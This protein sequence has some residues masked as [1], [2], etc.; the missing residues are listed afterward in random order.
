MNIG[1][2]GLIGNFVV[3]VS[4]FQR[5]CAK[6]MPE[7]VRCDFVRVTIAQLIGSRPV[8]LPAASAGEQA[9]TVWFQILQVFSDRVDYLIADEDYTLFIAFALIDCDLPSDQIHILRTE[10]ECLTHSQT[11]VGHDGNKRMVALAG[12]Q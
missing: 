7:F 5:V 1:M 4:L 11:G 6:E 8:K 9:V 10:I 2:P 3:A 12:L